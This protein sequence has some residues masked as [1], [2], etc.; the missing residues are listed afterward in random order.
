MTVH[1]PR[2]AEAP[3]GGAWFERPDPE[4]D[5]HDAHLVVVLDDSS[6]AGA[7][8][9]F[10]RI[11]AG[12]VGE[13]LRGAWRSVR[14][15]PLGM[16][17]IRRST[18]DRPPDL[19][20]VAARE[21][22][23][24]LAAEGGSGDL[25]CTVVRTVASHDELGEL[26][27]GVRRIEE[28]FRLDLLPVRLLACAV[29]LRPVE[30]LNGEALHELP[31]LALSPILLN[32][33]P[34][35]GPLPPDLVAPAIAE[36]LE[37]LVGTGPSVVFGAFEVRQHRKAFVVALDAIEVPNEAEE[38]FLGLRLVD[39]WLRDLLRGDPP[40]ER[41]L[42]KPPD[43]VRQSV[44]RISAVARASRIKT[45]RAAQTRF[46][47]AAKEIAGLVEAG[48]LSQLPLAGQLDVLG[49]ANERLTVPG[50]GLRDRMLDELAGDFQRVAAI[51][52]ETRGAVHRLLGTYSNVQLA[53]ETLMK[54]DA[55]LA[56][57]FDR[58][59]GRPLG[60]PD[61]RTE[62]ALIV[63]LT[64][65]RERSPIPRAAPLRTLLPWLGLLLLATAHLA[66]AQP[67]L[68]EPPSWMVEWLGPR[69]GYALRAADQATVVLFPVLVW[70]VLQYLRVWAER[71]KAARL[72]ARRFHQR[73]LAW[74]AWF[75]EQWA[76]RQ[77]REAV[78]EVL[79]DV[80]QLRERLIVV[81]THVVQEAERLEREL[82]GRSFPRRTAR[83]RRQLS[84]LFERVARRRGLD[85]MIADLRGQA[86]AKSD[87]AVFGRLLAEILQSMALD[88][89]PVTEEHALLQS[90]VRR[91]IN[92]EIGR[93]APETLDSRIPDPEATVAQMVE[94][95]RPA[96][97][98]LWRDWFFGD[99]Q[100]ALAVAAEA[101]GFVSRDRPDRARAAVLRIS[102]EARF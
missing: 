61:D 30:L 10:E 99:T 19:P 23:G 88:A 64:E 95:A 42:P 18:L 79:R 40:A 6:A 28:I 9:V 33:C 54:A 37:I 89:G 38:R 47:R 86:Y 70:Q 35:A 87:P 43:A 11:A 71:R 84:D 62:P 49:T 22:W 72:P 31:E 85:W 26:V 8:L 76:P 50:T 96:G 17:G 24:T 32:L 68:P 14:M 74:R 69:S 4:P 73:L 44:R 81:R 67:P 12:R 13:D 97:N 2:E 46:R 90:L 65:V 20:L 41:G 56:E 75:E 48:V 93:L 58:R 16:S 53:E 92:E 39:V 59:P 57:A 15:S 3:L 1:V 55:Q 7:A 21:V 36:F 5:S 25:V 82:T 100:S 101:A 91:A 52:R 29:L 34:P 66:A 63:D 102:I 45:I 60:E 83:S 77:V 80:Q 27:E 51:R 78:S 98:M 94:R